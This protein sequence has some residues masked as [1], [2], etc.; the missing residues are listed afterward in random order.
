MALIKPV[1]HVDKEDKKNKG[2]SLI[3]LDFFT[4]D[5]AV[6][7][8]NPEPSTPE[9][10]RRGRP[11]KKKN[12][13]GE[14]VVLADE[15][16][17]LEQYQ[18]NAPYLDSYKETNNMLR[19][20]VIQIDVLNNDIQQELQIIKNS[21]TLKRKYEYISEMSGTSS[22]LLGTKISA[23][24][25]MNKVITDCHNLEMKRIKD[26]KI[27]VD[28]NDDKHIMDLYNAFVTTPVGTNYVP[29]GPSMT[30]MT[31]VNGSNGIVRADINPS[32]DIGY[33]N[34]LRNMT[35]EQNRMRM[36]RNPNIKTVVVYNQETGDRNFD[37][38]DTSTGQSIPNMPMPPAFVLDDMNINIRT[39]TARNSNTDMDFPLIVVGRPDSLNNY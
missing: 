21:K 13:N 33:D 1:Y 5:K 35:P 4:S 7:P 29:L 39:G 14:N 6:L 2:E 31:L 8:I 38:I 17:P 16:E 15:S 3:N 28:Q 9:P 36:E 37:V 26:L 18:T 12:I 11:P 19:S 30:D 22:S 24:R 10:P 32:G 27:E 23:I 34:Y 25:E 20:S